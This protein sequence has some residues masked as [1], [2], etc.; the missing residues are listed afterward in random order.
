ME[1]L[2]AVAVE[3]T[4]GVKMEVGELDFAV[5]LYMLL[6]GMRAAVEKGRERNVFLE[7]LEGRDVAKGGLGCRGA[8]C[9]Y[10]GGCVAC[11]RGG[12]WAAL[13]KVEAFAG[14][15]GVQFCSESEGVGVTGRVSGDT[16]FET[17]CTAGLVR[18]AN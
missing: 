7:E 8:I 12:E 10:M 15:E 1:F 13:C 16:R 18:L 9:E 4:V 11:Y 17:Y 3:E 6:G 2:A 14:F 5:R